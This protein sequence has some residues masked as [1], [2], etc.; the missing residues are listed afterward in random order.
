MSYPKRLSLLDSQLKQG[1]LRKHFVQGSSLS[2]GGG[3]SG[4]EVALVGNEYE[5]ISAA[6]DKLA[7][8]LKEQVT[9][10]DSVRI[11]FDT[12]QPELSFNINRERAQD[13]GV[14]LDAISQ[15]LRVMVDKY[16]VIDLNIEDQA[17][18]V[19]V[20]SAGDAIND[21]DDLLNIFVINAQGEL[22]PLSSLI[23]VKERGVA[24]E[25]DRHAQR[26]A[27]ELDIGVKPGTPIGNL[28]S[29]T[30]NIANNTLP[31]NVNILFLGE[32]AT[33]D[34]T[35][36]DVALTFFIAIAVVFLVLAAQFESLSTDL[37]VMLTV[38]YGLASAVFA[39]ML[40][41][42]SI[43]LYSQIGL[44]MLIGLMTKNAILL[45]EFMDQMRDE[46]RSVHDAIMEGVK[47]RLRPVTMTVM[48]TILGS[49]PLILSL[50]AGAE[51]RNAIGWVIF[52]GLGL[53]TLFTLYLTPLI[54]SLIAPHVKPRS[55]AGQKLAEQWQAGEQKGLIRDT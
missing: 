36:Y 16:D 35:S 15:T 27:I 46:G 42:Q 3:G 39:L 13:L 32:A 40:T 21:P 52:G 2:F 43:N 22:I 37:I 4:L 20:G 50:G 14:P 51:A 55:H 45:V 7:A 9:A 41:G 29:Q 30:R 54:Y 44:I 23:S 24:A 53:S 48:S 31:P 26:R 34:E 11:Q 10:I 6:A 33:L 5:A 8:A 25:L 17:V 47:V 28:L 49:L 18:P 19:M 1:R 12:S 38:P